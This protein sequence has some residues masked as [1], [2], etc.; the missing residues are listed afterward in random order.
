MMSANLRLPCRLFGRFLVA[1]FARGA[2]NVVG[3]P[4][5]FSVTQIKT[6]CATA[7]CI[8]WGYDDLQRV[9]TITSQLL[10]AL[11]CA[12]VQFIMGITLGRFI[13]RQINPFLTKPPQYLSYEPNA[14][15]WKGNLTLPSQGVG[16]IVIARKK[17]AIC[18]HSLPIR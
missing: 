18:T 12:E 1:L 14:A 13:L 3:I 16:P 7:R 10:P 5:L 11:Q 6:E 2:R 9:K 4:I 15:H 17:G 8:P